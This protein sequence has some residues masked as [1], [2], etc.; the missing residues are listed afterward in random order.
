MVKNQDKLKDALREILPIIEEFIQ[1]DA[2]EDEDMSEGFEVEDDDFF[3]GFDPDTEDSEGGELD[4]MY[5]NNPECTEDDKAA[6]KKMSAMLI[7]KKM[8]KGKNRK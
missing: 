2:V 6:R 8:G 1:S 4:E 7:S 5:G 3:E